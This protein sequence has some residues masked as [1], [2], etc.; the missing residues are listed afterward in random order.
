MGGR[1]FDI[2]VM[3]CER[4]PSYIDRTLASMALSDREGMLSVS[5]VHLIVDSANQ[6]YLKDYSTSGLVQPHYLTE[7][8]EQSQKALE[9]RERIYLTLNRS[10]AIRLP[11]G[12]TG[13]V[14]VEDD[15]LFRQGW[16]GCLFEALDHIE[17]STFALWLYKPTDAC[18]HHP[19]TWRS[20][21]HFEPERLMSGLCGVFLSKKAVLALQGEPTPSTDQKADGDFGLYLD[22]KGVSRL[23]L[24]R[25][26]VQHEGYVSSDEESVW[27]KGSPSFYQPWKPLSAQEWQEGRGVFYSGATLPR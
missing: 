2:C 21:Y 19:S 20:S 5:D 10:L 9:A 18:R 14:I 26:I 25:D 24:L 15:V 27:H 12:H 4:T 22:Q 7:E 1:S 23:A 6:W 3:T 8:Q 13:R 16:V 17:D 11:G